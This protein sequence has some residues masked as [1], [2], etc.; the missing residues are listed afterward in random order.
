VAAQIATAAAA[1]HHANA[2]V[3]END[4]V[5]NRREPAVEQHGVGASEALAYGLRH[6]R[7]A[8]H[9]DQA[10]AALHEDVIG[11]LEDKSAPEPT[12]PVA[13]AVR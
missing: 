1:S 11:Y 4:I 12:A 8:W 2:N 13:I 10:R 7:R 5:R 9:E 6:R 3:R